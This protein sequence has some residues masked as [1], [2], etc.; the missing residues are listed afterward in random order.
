MYFGP[1]DFLIFY[2]EGAFVRSFL[3]R[4]VGS[5]HGR[6]HATAAIDTVNT[7]TEGE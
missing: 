7:L 4:C 1:R 3:G 5:K 6:C 2:C